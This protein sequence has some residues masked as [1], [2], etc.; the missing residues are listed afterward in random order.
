MRLTLKR[1]ANGE[2]IREMQI[3]FEM[4]RRSIPDVKR[5]SQESLSQCA[6]LGQVC[7]FEGKN[8]RDFMAF[9]IRPSIVANES[10]VAPPDSLH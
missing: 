7:K 9:T 10:G 5:L 8:G 1:V 3:L 6:G 2:S 4:L